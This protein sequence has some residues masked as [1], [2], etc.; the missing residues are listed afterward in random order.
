VLRLRVLS[1]AKDGCAPMAGAVVD[2]WHCDA[3]GVYSD[4]RDPGFNTIGKK[5]LRG[6]QRTDADGNVAFTTIYP[7]WYEGRTVHIHFKVRAATGSGRNYEFTSQFYF[8]DSIT[9][10]IHALSPYAARGPRTVRNA[11]D[12]LFRDRGSRLILPLVKSSAG[13]SA[14]FDVGLRL[15]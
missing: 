9:D 14:S 12:G 15:V 6:S 1:A 13:Y 7:G 3:A 5:F 11:G 2:I 4:A 8:E 10:R